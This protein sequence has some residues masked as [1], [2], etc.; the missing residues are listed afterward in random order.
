MRF[1]LG[2]FNFGTVPSVMNLPVWADWYYLIG[3]DIGRSSVVLAGGWRQT[4]GCQVSKTAA[5]HSWKIGCREA[6]CQVFL[7]FE[8][9]VLHSRNQFSEVSLVLSPIL[10]SPLL[11]S[12][13]KIKNRILD[14]I[15][16]RGVTVTTPLL[17]AARRRGNILSTIP[18]LVS[19]FASCTDFICHF[20]DSQNCVWGKYLN[21]RKGY[22]RMKIIVE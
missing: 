6:S 10:I 11:Y 18:L 3:F 22:Y 21:W 7:R 12:P 19:P 16:L 20:S 13:L 9:I 15:S 1:Q 8:D 5:L 17:S 14:L 2:W 4:V